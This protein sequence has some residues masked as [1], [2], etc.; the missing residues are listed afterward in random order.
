MTITKRLVDASEKAEKA[1]I[2]WDGDLK[3]FGLLVLPS[4]SKSYVAQYRNAAGRSRRFT[5]GRHPTFTPD[6]ARRQ[7]K[8]VL[9]AAATGSDPVAE[10]KHV[11]STPTV[12][13]LFDRYLDEH[14]RLNNAAS[15]QAEVERFVERILKPKLGNLQ[16]HAVTGR[17]LAKLHTDLSATPRQANLVL[18]IASK[19]FS[20]AEM[21][22][23]RPPHSNP[24]RGIKRFAEVERERFLSRDELARL[25]VALDEASTIGLPWRVEKP[26]SKHLPTGER[27]T[28]PNAMAL[29]CVRLLL[30]TGARLSEILKLEWAHVDLVGGTIALPGQKGKQRRDHPISEPALD[31]LKGLQK[32]R[33][34]KWVLPGD[35]KGTRHLNREVAETVW[36]KLR[37]RAEIEDVRL[38]DLRHTVGTLAGQL[39]ANAFLIQHLLRH[40]TVAMTGRYV[41]ADANPIRD[42]SDAVGDRIAEGLAG[43]SQIIKGERGK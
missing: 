37:H 14:V 33:R 21:W 27:R 2:V 3:G 22:E 19:A 40:R 6:E 34:G 15:T 7:A 5:I 25:G 8:A 38:H 17:D 1:Y 10:R 4:G 23:L 39:G 9:L 32:R 26:A 43:G 41:N 13:K 36:Q 20:L 16:V 30:F 24:A 35:E 31:I 12:A 11:R 28:K 29:E 18:A 42:V